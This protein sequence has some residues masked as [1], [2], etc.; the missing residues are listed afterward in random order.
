MDL[1]PPSL[2]DALPFFKYLVGK[3]GHAFR[4]AGC[5]HGHALFRPRYQQCLKI[6]LRTQILGA[7]T[8]IVLGLPV[9]AE[10]HTAELQSRFDLVCRPLLETK[11]KQISTD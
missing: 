11:Q 10:E 8:Q 3:S 6:Q 7:A 5:E 4:A 9:R 1:L 2:R